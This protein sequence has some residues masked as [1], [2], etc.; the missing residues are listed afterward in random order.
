M[1]QVVGWVAPELPEQRPRYVMGVG[2]PEDILAAVERGADM[3]DCVIPTRYARG[4]T[5]FTR[6]G[7]P[8]IG[9]KTH[10][11]DTSKLDG[12]CGCYTC[13]HFSRLTLRHLH[14]A[15]EPVFDTLASI[16]NL[17]FYQD[18]MADCRHEIERGRFAAWKAAWLKRYGA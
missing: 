13:A 4:G 14:Y 9:D 12:K 15:H 18:L 3:F 2:L 1:A 7:R 16:H 10:R 6:K 17:R 8:R 11:H 5:L